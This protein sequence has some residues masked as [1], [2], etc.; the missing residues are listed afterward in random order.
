MKRIPQHHIIISKICISPFEDLSNQN[1][2]STL[3]CNAFRDRVSEL[4][5]VGWWAYENV[6]D[7][8]R[9][10]NSNR[11]FLKLPVQIGNTKAHN[12]HYIV[13]FWQIND[14]SK[15]SNM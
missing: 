8:K 6:K 7:T 4:A 1:I 3:S 15:S 10:E 11:Y 2:T 12:I 14:S 5:G 9:K 13:M